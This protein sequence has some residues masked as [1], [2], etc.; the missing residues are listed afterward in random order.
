MLHKKGDPTLLD[1]YRPIAHMNNQSTLKLWTTLIKD[2]GS[3]YAEI[4]GIL[5]DQQNGFRQHRS[6]HDA[7]SYII[8]TMENA[9]LHNKDIYDSGKPLR[10]VVA[11]SSYGQNKGD[12][13]VAWSSE[14]SKSISF[15][16]EVAGN[17][18]KVVF[19]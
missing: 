16:Q 13:D 10:V 19:V 11:D 17:L 12:W 1:N 6:M 5:C 9:K 15:A 18:D 7:L 2:A 14:F 3:K 4:H 8:M